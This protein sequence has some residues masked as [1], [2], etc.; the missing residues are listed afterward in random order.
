MYF[1]V[2][3]RS[4]ISLVRATT[5]PRTGIF[6][7]PPL[8]AVP[9]K[10]GTWAIQTKGLITQVK[11]KKVLTPGQSSE[12]NSESPYTVKHPLLSAILETAGWHSPNS[13]TLTLVDNS[14]WVVL[15]SYRLQCEAKWYKWSVC[16]EMCI[17][18]LAWSESRASAQLQTNISG[19][20]GR[21]ICPSLTEV[22]VI[23]FVTTI[24]VLQVTAHD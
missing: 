24:A 13:T 23:T 12:T 2:T 14:E 19:F 8:Q 22:A 7:C 17:G 1:S 20:R 18:Q 11:R 5:S 16:A 6:G 4:T 9:V 21:F 3:S 15:R 10:G